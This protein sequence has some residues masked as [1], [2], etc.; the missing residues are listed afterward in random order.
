MIVGTPIPSSAVPG[1]CPGTNGSIASGT[2]LMS[3]TYVCDKDVTFNGTVTVGGAVKIYITN[4]PGTNTTLRLGGSTVN[5][6]GDPVNLQIVKVD[7]GTIDPGSGSNGTDF[8]GIIDAPSA[9][10]TVNGGNMTFQGALVTNS[11]RVNGSPNLE[12]K[13]DQRILALVSEDWRV[14]DYAEIASGSVGF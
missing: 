12:F 9:D 4:P 3:G 7:G 8:T 11:F 5:K 1:G 14:K 10:L 6:G 2:V 13:Y